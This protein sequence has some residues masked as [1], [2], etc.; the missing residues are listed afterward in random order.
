MNI[1]P[2]PPELTVINLFSP[3]V[4]DVGMTSVSRRNVVLISPISANSIPVSPG[5][6]INIFPTLPVYVDGESVCPI[7]VGFPSIVIVTS[8]PVAVEFT[9]LPTKSRY[10]TAFVIVTP[11][12]LTLTFPPSAQINLL[13]VKSYCKKLPSLFCTG[14]STSVICD[15]V[16][17]FH[18]YELVG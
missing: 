11:S 2:V 4:N 5:L 17:A 14:V 18:L 1:S 15:I 3:P 8:S 12:F 7:N 9:P 16:N 10:P 6:T 13:F